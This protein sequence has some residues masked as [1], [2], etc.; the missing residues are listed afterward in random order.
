MFPKQTHCRSESEDTKFVHKILNRYI[1]YFEEAE[2]RLD[3]LNIFHIVNAVIQWA[4][5]GWSA[6]GSYPAPSTIRTNAVFH[7]SI[8]S[9][10]IGTS[11]FAEA[12]TIYM[13]T[14]AVISHLLCD[15]TMGLALEV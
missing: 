7:Y 3:W 8:R 9:P 4:N 10:F 15:P 6:I 13:K 11:L 12:L 5:S 1:S 14:R 2:S